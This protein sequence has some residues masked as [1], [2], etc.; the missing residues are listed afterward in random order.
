L[1]DIITHDYVIDVMVAEATLA[2]SIRGQPAK[3]ED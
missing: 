3:Q 1:V 2:P